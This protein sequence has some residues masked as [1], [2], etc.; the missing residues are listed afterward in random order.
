MQKT[1]QTGVLVKVLFLFVLTWE[2][3]GLLYKLGRDKILASALKLGHELLLWR[4]N[5]AVA[6]TYIQGGGAKRK[7]GGPSQL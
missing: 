6:R 2:P 3:R 7:P 1:P 5:R 4:P